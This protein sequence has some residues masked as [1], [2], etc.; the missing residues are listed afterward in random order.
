VIFLELLSNKIKRRKLMQF[1]YE[2]SGNWSCKYK[3]DAKNE[4][5][6]MKIADEKLGNV[7][8]IDLEITDKEVY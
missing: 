2:A 4:D 3:I 5:E 1:I 8:D 6:A 7:K